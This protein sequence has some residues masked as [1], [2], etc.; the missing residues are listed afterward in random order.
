MP[1]GN[2][3]MTPISI[4]GE[5]C[6]EWMDITIDGALSMPYKKDYV[7]IECGKRMSITSTTDATDRYQKYVYYPAAKGDGG[8]DG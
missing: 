7:C 3:D 4:V 2:V 5:H 8:T 1:K 6:C